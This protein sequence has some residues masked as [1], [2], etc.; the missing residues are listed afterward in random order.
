MRWGWDGGWPMMGIGMVVM[1]AVMVIVVWLIVRA[2]SPRTESRG[3][4]SA[5]ELLRRRFAEGEIDAEEYQ[6]RLQTLRT[7]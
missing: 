1:V 6:Q 4:E 2:T 3:S 5:E 7:R